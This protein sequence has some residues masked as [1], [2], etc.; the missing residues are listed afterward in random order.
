M[1]DSGLKAGPT[2]NDIRAWGREQ[3]REVPDTGRLPAGLRADYLIAHTEG[4]PDEDRPPVETAPRVV[5]E[6]AP[7]KSPATR[8]K[9][10]FTSAT[11]PAPKGK[12]RHARVPVDKVISTF[13]DWA[14]KAA[15][16]VN[17]PVSNMLKIQTPVA[18][19]ILED[20]VKGT[21]IDRALQPLARSNK[22]VELIWAMTAAPILVGLISVKPASM[23]VALPLL[24]DALRS[25]IDIAGP[26]IEEI[27]EK[28]AEFQ[29]TYGARID[30]ML[31]MIFEV[32]ADNV[33]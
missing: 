19:L 32:E 13:W 2:L 33:E 29:A 21:V 25:Y 5:A 23:P 7:A 4:M 22:T 1:T 26:K 12:V 11:K 20:A 15:R 17:A 24:K 31:M 8:A 30:E 18:G 3:G 6:K 16:P 10:L 28:E 14:A 27:V 9:E